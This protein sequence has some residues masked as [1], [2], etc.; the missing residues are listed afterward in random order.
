MAAPVTDVNPAQ[1]YRMPRLNNRVFTNLAFPNLPHA[2]AVRLSL[3]IAL[4][5]GLI[6]GCGEKPSVR[7]YTIP[8]KMPESL[9]TR[10]RL[11][12]AIIPQEKEVWFVKVLGPAEAVK[13]ADKQIRDFAKS[14]NV[15]ERRTG[16][17]QT[18][19]GL[20]SRR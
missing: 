17:D 6:A 5:V 20:E 8:G 7:E 12:G 4:G 19:R 3:W 2:F 1:A 18:A 14:L 15:H 9:L 10:D 16:L 11:L 13:F